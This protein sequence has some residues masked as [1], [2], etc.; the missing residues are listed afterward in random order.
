VG[1]SE[2]NGSNSPGLYTHLGLAELMLAEAGDPGSA[3]LGQAIASLRAGLGRPGAA[4][5]WTRLACA[6]LLADGPSEEAAR[7]LGIALATAP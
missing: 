1:I 4:H 6:E 7:A 5:A 2:A 3:M